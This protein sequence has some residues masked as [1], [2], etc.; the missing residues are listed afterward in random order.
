MDFNHD[1]ILDHADTTNYGL[2]NAQ[3]QEV[4]VFALKTV[5]TR[6]RVLLRSI[7]NFHRRSADSA[8]DW[9]FECFDEEADGIP[10]ARLAWGMTREP[11]RDGLSEPSI[12]GGAFNGKESSRV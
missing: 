11:G 4:E 12:S 3:K 10:L 6:P 9:T 2:K 5:D 8:N 7:F 1:G